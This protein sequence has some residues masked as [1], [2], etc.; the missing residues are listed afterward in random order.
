MC[1]TV[2]SKK[3]TEFRASVWI[4]NDNQRLQFD[5]IKTEKFKIYYGTCENLQRRTPPL[6]KHD[7][8]PRNMQIKLFLKYI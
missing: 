8:K 1:A 2:L 7:F 5:T 3:N 6:R 4:K